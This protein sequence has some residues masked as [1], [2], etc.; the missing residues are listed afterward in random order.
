M[1]KRFSLGFRRTTR[2]FFKSEFVNPFFR[3]SRFIDILERMRRER[4][5]EESGEDEPDVPPTP[6]DNR[7]DQL[8]HK[9]SMKRPSVNQTSNEIRATTFAS[10]SDANLA[11]SNRSLLGHSNDRLTTINRDD[12]SLSSSSSSTSSSLSKT[13]S[14]NG[15]HNRELLIVS[16]EE[17]LRQ[18]KKANSRRNRRAKKRQAIMAMRKSHSNDLQTNRYFIQK[19]SNTTYVW[20]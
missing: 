20:Q 4:A 2:E 11:K 13:S 5:A 12:D 9:S 6:R 1:R 15:A 19:E 3:P 14:R 8:E 7:T 17:K 10:V 18:A 16:D